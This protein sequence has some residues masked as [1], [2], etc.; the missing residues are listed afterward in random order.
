MPDCDILLFAE[1]HQVAC[2]DCTGTQDI[3]DQQ[4][5]GLKLAPLCTEKT[6]VVKQDIA[7]MKSVTHRI[8]LLDFPKI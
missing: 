4:I 3:K 8:P 1:F 5:P 7:E 2:A 6:G